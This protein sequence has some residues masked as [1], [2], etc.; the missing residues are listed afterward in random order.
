MNAPSIIII[1]ALLWAAM[2]GSF[3]GPNLLFGGMIGGIAALL[4]RR[5]L[6]NSGSF[7]R[8]G[9][10]LSLLG[11][12]LYELM[13]SAVRVAVIVLRPDMSKVIEPAIV[14]V[15]LTVKS[16]MEITLLASL[17]TLTPGTLSIDVSQ[18]RT[19]LY[20]HTLVLGDREAVIA[21]IKN[22]FEKKVL[23]VFE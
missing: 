14:A 10:I 2:T 4:L 19:T 8:M 12:F 3:S 16:D 17:I 1:L 20:V 7:H 6:P 22:G 23:E 21:E 9:R 15:P 5:F 13:A 11:L 18:D